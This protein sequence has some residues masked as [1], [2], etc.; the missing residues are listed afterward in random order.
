[1]RLNKHF[2][3][4]LLLVI[5]VVPTFVY[6]L[7][8]VATQVGLQP[9]KVVTYFSSGLFFSFM[10][11]TYYDRMILKHDVSYYNTIKKNKDDI[12]KIT[13]EVREVKAIISEYTDTGITYDEIAVSASIRRGQEEKV[14]VKEGDLDSD[15][16][17]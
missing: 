6:L 8:L 9:D 5:L 7:G 1:M 4:K 12:D 11:V 15:S 14:V 17:E 3:I 10:L 13:S 16:N 2:F